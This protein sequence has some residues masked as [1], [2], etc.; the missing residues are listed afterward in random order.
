VNKLIVVY[1]RDIPAQVIGREGRRSAFKKVL[2]QRF[3]N[4]IDRAAMRAG[5]GSSDAYMADWRR[6]SRP[7]PGDLGQAVN[8]E[9]TR[10]EAEFP[11]SRLD[12]VAR[13]SG[14]VERSE[15]DAGAVPRDG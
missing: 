6:E 3:Q 12:A 11:D 8:D 13:A 1:W 9:A 7:C 15:S 2:P 5:R 14:I 10:L 4:T